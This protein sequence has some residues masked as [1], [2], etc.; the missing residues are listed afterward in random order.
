[1]FK[2]LTLTLLTL[3]LSANLGVSQTD[4]KEA[5]RIDMGSSVRSPDGLW[6]ISMIRPTPAGDYVLIGI[7]DGEKVKITEGAK[8]GFK[9]LWSMDGRYMV[10]VKPVG[11]CTMADVFELD[12]KNKKVKEVFA[13]ERYNRRPYVDYI[14]E[15]WDIERGIA[16]FNVYENVRYLEGRGR[17]LLSV[18]FIFLDGRS[19]YY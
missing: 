6:K 10:V 11:F 2:G 4:V 17:R 3:T 1:M 15:R 12:N 14:F 16:V 18:E 8:P 7:C 19:V 13:S 9:I 5:I